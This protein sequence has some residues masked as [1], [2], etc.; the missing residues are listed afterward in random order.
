MDPSN[1]GEMKEEEERGESLLAELAVRAP[2]LPQML[3][4]NRV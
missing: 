3:N 4:V 2:H 1:N